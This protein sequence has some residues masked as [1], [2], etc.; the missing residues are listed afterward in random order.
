MK[1]E[2][3]ISSALIA[4]CL[5]GGQKDTAAQTYTQ[6]PVTISS[7]RVRAEDGKIYY[8]H[9]VLDHQ[10]LYS[11]AK[12]YGVS[13][14]DICKA[15]PKEDLKTQGLKK[16]SIIYVPYM[17]ETAVKNDAV[18]EETAA[19]ETTRKEE[20]KTGPAPSQTAQS[21]QTETKKAKKGEDYFIHVSRWYEDIDDIAYKYSIPVN[22]LMEYN[23]LTSHKLKNRQK[24]KV[25]VDYKTA[26][27]Q[28]DAQENIENVKQVEQKEE[29]KQEIV[30]KE[31]KESVD[32]PVGRADRKVNALLMLPLKASAS[33]PNEN[34]FDFYCGAL[35][36]VDKLKE[37]GVDIDLSVYDVSTSL[38]I[39]AERLAAS[40]LAIG[41]V[42]R[43]QLERVL[44]LAPESTT[45]ISPLD[46][47]TADLAETHRNMFQAPATQREQYADLLDWMKSERKAADKVF[48]ISEKGVAGTSGMQ[49]MS[50]LIENSGLNPSYYSYNILQGREAVNS[51]EGMMTKSGVNRVIINSES[52]AFV[53]DAVR[54]L[55]TLVYRKN[56]VVLYSPSKIRSFDTIDAE[57]LHN[58]NTRISTS[59]YVDYNSRETT[60]FLM[61]YRALYNAEPTQFAFQGYDLTYYFISQ[62]ARFGRNWVNRMEICPVTSMIQTD[63]RFRREDG[64]GFTNKAV[65]RIEYKPDYI[66]NIVD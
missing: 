34:S 1:F 28:K 62:K 51:L 54:N 47:R 56:N 30:K 8:C 64:N 14:D 22:V 45:I 66:V 63:F 41:P 42:S 27:P 18:K 55:A 38:P 49:M 19:A 36:A 13:I 29:S 32:E 24:I 12:A 50:E 17:K 21:V 35:L 59:Y 2:I 9:K 57:N 15:N 4:A 40:D 5:L 44:E 39:T 33:E 43:T 16:D 61:K 60:D 58:L 11:V 37:Q 46:P 7:E 31:E 10:T 6:E 52:E 20:T 26:V 48:V 23:G 3:I 65:R 25:P 53:N